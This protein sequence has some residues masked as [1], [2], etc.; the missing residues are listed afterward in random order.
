MFTVR[1]SFLPR[2]LARKLMG[3][4][5][6]LGL[7]SY[8]ISEILH[9]S[10][11]SQ[12]GKFFDMPKSTKVAPP[13]QA[14][15]QEMWG[16]KKEPKVEL[17]TE[18]DAMEVEQVKELKGTLLIEKHFHVF[19]HLTLSAESFKRKEPASI[20]C[21]LFRCSCLRFLMRCVASPKLKK[22]RV[23]DSDDELDPDDLPFQPCKSS[24][25]Y[26]IYRASDQV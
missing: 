4:Q 5:Q 11:H 19:V 9:F 21:M 24:S 25:S 7:F 14:S 16:K 10:E 3:R 26:S 13:Q 23:I 20:I 2:A 22:R 1:V 8:N 17:K 15:L 18:S 12:L 6:T